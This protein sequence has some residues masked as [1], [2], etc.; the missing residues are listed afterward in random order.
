MAYVLT[1][2]KTKFSRVQLT[3]FINGNEP[4]TVDELYDLQKELFAK[5]KIP[6][7]HLAL[8]TKY[9]AP[10]HHGSCASEIHDQTKS[11]ALIRTG[12][13]AESRFHLNP[14]LYKIMLNNVKL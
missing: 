11:K 9:Q 5:D 3:L 10:N 14:E 2:A 12:T 1:P 13:R 6:R 8:G 4:L 7:D